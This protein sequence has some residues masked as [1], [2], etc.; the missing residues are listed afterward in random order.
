MRIGVNTRL[1]VD[2][3]MDGI[4]WFS[5]E[6]LQRM[7]RKHPND[8]FVFFFDRTPDKK[9]LFAD[10]I[11]PVVVNPPARHPFLWYLFFEIGIKKALQKEKIDLFFSPDG[12]LCL[13]TNIPTLL[14]M[15]DINFEHYPQMSSFWTRKYYQHFFPKFARKADKLV[16]VSHF[17]RQDISQHYHIPLDKIA[18][19]YNAVAEDFFEI[20][21]EEQQAVKNTYCGGE[22]YFIFAGTANKR[23]N[24]VNIL[25]A[26]DEFRKAGN[27]AKLL[28]AGMKKYW[29]KDMNQTLNNMQYADDVVFTGYISTTD[30]NKLLSAAI[31][32]VYVSLFEGFGVPIIE[33]FACGTPVITSDVTAMPEVADTAALLVNP[34]K[35][36][37]ISNAMQ[38]L[39]NNKELQE[40][41]IKKGK[42]RSSYFSWDKSETIIWQE[43][44]KLYEKN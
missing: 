6:I 5:Y 14:V 15:H 13:N 44:I 29:D 27:H 11:K 28:F 1:L 30:M 19:A 31:G 42:I 24:V 36:D 32:L 10:N 34:N 20:S 25:L 4:A 8:E 35:V 7:V 12:W 2:G 41:L 33:A 9:F 40:T 43:M 38:Q 22:D 18:V 26:F 21:K 37:E 23:K 39:F 16:T 3:K 17:S